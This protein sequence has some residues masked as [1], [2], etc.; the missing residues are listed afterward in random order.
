M[1]FLVGRGKL[2]FPTLA[3][4][5]GPS[6]CH[7]IDRNPPMPYICV[8]PVVSETRKDLERMKN[9]N[10]TNVLVKSLIIGLREG[11]LQASPF[12]PNRP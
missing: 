8:G 3:T 1:P 2:F 9:E 11:V 12:N 10:D 5:C 4:I 7:G 6:A